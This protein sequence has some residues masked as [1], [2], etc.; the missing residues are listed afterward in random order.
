L[1]SPNTP[2]LSDF[3][4]ATDA[5]A[6]LIGSGK[7]YRTHLPP[8]YWSNGTTSEQTDIFAMGLT[9]FRSLLNIADWRAVIN[10][11]PNLPDHMQKGTL[12]KR[13]GFEEFIP[14]KL[15][16]IVRKACHPDPAQRFLTAHAF[17]QRL[18]TINFKIDWIRLADNEWQ[19]YCDAGKLHRC[20]ADLAN[21]TVTIS[22]NGRRVRSECKKHR[23]FTAAIS[24]INQYVAETT[25]K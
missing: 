2:K 7:G 9:L 13:I 11:V 14:D 12:V 23:S 15:R 20:V 25:L 6:S 24:Q 8:D 22:V 1:L 17:G 19:G 16:R 18:D 10:A 21:N 5:G 3:G 4:L